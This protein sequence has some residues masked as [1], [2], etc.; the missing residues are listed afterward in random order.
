MTALAP[1]SASA[2]RTA[3]ASPMSPRVSVIRRCGVAR[4]QPRHRFVVAR[5]QV[6]V[7]DDVAARLGEGF[8][9]MTPHVPG[10]TGDE[11]DAHGRPI[12]W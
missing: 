7:D 2:R 11:H 9:G 12:D 10:A 5:G 3:A 8:D 4:G 6:V 1:D